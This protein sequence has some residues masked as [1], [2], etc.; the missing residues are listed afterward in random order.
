[1]GLIVGLGVLVNTFWGTIQQHVLS[2]ATNTSIS[3]LL[4]ETNEERNAGGLASLTLNSQLNQAAQAKAN[5]MAARDYWSHNTPEGNPP[6]VFFDNAGYDYTAAGENLAYGFD[7]STETV[8]GWMN[9]PGHK[10]NIMHTA[11]QEVGF[12]M[13][14]SENYQGT[15]P[16][17]IVVAM[18]G[19]P[20]VASATAPAP[21]EPSQPTAVA[22]VTPTPTPTSEPAANPIATEEPTP[23]T[24][25][26]NATPAPAENTNKTPETQTTTPPATVTPRKVARVQLL[27]GSTAAWSTFAITAV[28]AIGVVIFFLRH[29][30]LLRQMLIKS[31]LF[32]H[33][34]PLFDIAVVAIVTISII[35]IQTDG[36]IR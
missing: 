35:L 31:E 13:A 9:S 18:Y 2:Y 7:N 16:E 33:K 1:M 27:S 14:N 34:H 5:D 17:T 8:I 32:V 6:W 4:Q 21:S 24:P 3:G 11:Y 19:A 15:G 29:G 20:K 26:A 10:A 22:E 36:I 28:A 23:P 25:E 30:L 12:G